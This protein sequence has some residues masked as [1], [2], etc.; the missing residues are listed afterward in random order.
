MQTVRQHYDPQPR[1][2]DAAWAK[3]MYAE[4]LAK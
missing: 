3:S 1:G 2:E 4:F